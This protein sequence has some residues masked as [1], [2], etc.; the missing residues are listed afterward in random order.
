MVLLFTIAKKATFKAFHNLK[1]YKYKFICSLWIKLYYVYDFD[2][3]WG[4]SGNK[5]RL[6]ATQ[7]PNVGPE[8]PQTG[9]FNVLTRCKDP[10]A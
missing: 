3:E 7:V 5:G 1:K 8:F 4:C 6:G 2:Q 9:P 10:L